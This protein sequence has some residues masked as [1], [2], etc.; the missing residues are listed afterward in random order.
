MPRQPLTNSD[1]AE[2]LAVEAQSAKMP[3]QKALR[4]ASRRA[5]LWPEEAAGLLQQGRSLT[6]LS[7]IG[8]YIE[9]LLT[10]WIDKPPAIPERPEI[11]RQFFTFTEAQKILAKKPV[12]LGLVKGDLQMQTTW[13]D[14]EGSDRKSTRLNSSHIP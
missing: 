9:K 4:R 6:E 3:T 10:R 11:R 8:P 7:G 5:F 14:G 2:L 12:W 13:S 1:I